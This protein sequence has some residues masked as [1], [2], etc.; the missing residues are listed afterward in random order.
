MCA[1]DQPLP[2]WRIFHL[3]PSSP[4][5]SQGDNRAGVT[6]PQPGH[7][8]LDW[9]SVLFRHSPW[10]SLLLWR[11]KVKAG[12]CL[13]SPMWD[14]SLGP[15]ASQTLGFGHYCG[16]GQA[17][18]P[19]FRSFISCQSCQLLDQGSIP[20]SLSF[21]IHKMGLVIPTFQKFCIFQESASRHFMNACAPPSGKS[22]RP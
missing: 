1:G 2:P 20:L 16:R 5:Q 10:A 11:K 7:W 12:P 22:S 14:S 21:S 9:R 3:H 6:H 13:S 19:E 18:R 17:S 8:L 4:P 15:L